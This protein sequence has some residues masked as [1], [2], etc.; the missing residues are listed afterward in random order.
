MKAWIVGL[1]TSPIFQAIAIPIAFL[2]IGV[3][4]KR[5]GRRDGDDSPRINDWAVST[6]ILLMTLGTVA[7]DLKNVKA[8]GDVIVLLLWVIGLLV[9]LFLSLDYDRYRSWKLDGDRNR[10]KR[11][12]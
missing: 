10:P 4:A 5:L 6:S 12:L 2:F 9:C 1:V 11:R 8:A 3:Y 7:A